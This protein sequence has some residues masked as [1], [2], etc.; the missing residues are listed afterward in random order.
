M[1]EVDWVFLAEGISY[2]ELTVSKVWEDN[3]YPGRPGS[4]TVDLLR[5]GQVFDTVTLDAGSQWTHTWTQ[6]DDRFQWSVQERAVDGYEAR[7]ATQ[8]DTVVI[9]NHM[10]YTPATARPDEHPDIAE[11]IANGTWGGAPTA[12]P[13]AAGTVPQTSDALP[14]TALVVILVAAAAAIVL[15]VVLRRRK[16][17]QDSRR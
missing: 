17:G 8:G 16:D 3:G 12:T 9:T 7:Y 13:A 6:L 2:Q 10:D 5:D 14:L 1:G 15:L 4:V 11:G